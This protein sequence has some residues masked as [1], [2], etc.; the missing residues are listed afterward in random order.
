MARELG[1]VQR[2]IKALVSREFA[3][4]ECRRRPNLPS[5]WESTLRWGLIDTCL[6]FV[7]FG[8][9]ILQPTIVIG[10]SSLVLGWSLSIFTLLVVLRDR[11]AFGK[12]VITI[13]VSVLSAIAL[14]HVS[15]HP[16]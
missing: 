5:K 16:P 15:R 9:G 4:A 10:I 3:A 14:T 7:L 6:T 11:N 12:S 8:I 13:S 2:T 1:R